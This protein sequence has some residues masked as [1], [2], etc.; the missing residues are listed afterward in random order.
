ME[1]RRAR[2]ALRHRLV[3]ETRAG[4]ALT[5]AR[6]VVVL[7]SSDPA[8]VFLSVRARTTGFEVADLETA[9][10]DRRS[11]VRMLAMRRTLWVVPRELVPVVD[12]AC[13]RVIAAR[14]RK[15]LVQSVEARAALVVVDPHHSPGPGPK[16]RSSRRRG[17]A[18]P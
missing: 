9:L 13:T 12:A 4:D 18:P 3:A 6:A 5:A 2:L 17:T 14:E 8:T 11:L 16:R 1:E 15:R 10:Y 7:H